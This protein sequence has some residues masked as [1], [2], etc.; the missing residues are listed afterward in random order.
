[1]SNTAQRLKLMEEKTLSH[2][3]FDVMWPVKGDLSRFCSN[4][5]GCI[6]I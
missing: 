1:M 5:W 2:M 6:L 4:Q 3:L